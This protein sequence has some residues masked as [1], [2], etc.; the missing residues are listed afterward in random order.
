MR[1][2]HKENRIYFRF[3]KSDW[4]LDGGAV[5]RSFIEEFKTRVDKKYRDYNEEKGEWSVDA[6]GE[7]VLMKMRERYF[8]EDTRQQDLFGG[9]DG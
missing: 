5:V 1:I 8:P 6:C 9:G 3:E 7:E 2:D 4:G